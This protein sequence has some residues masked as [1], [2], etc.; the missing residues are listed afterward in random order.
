MAHVNLTHV[1][2]AGNIYNW[3]LQPCNCIGSKVVDKRALP[4][5]AGTKPI[6]EHDVSWRCDD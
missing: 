5:A 4:A 3:Q 1:Y 6:D 2:P